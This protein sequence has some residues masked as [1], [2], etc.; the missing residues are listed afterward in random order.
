M[1]QEVTP[2]RGRLRGWPLVISLLLF[3]LF[4]LLLGSFVVPFQANVPEGYEAG[5]WWFRAIAAVVFVGIAWF[6]GIKVH[7]SNRVPWEVLFLVVPIAV[8]ISG[9][10]LCIASGLPRAD[11]LPSV[12]L[13]GVFVGI[14]E[15][16]LSRGLILNALLERMTVPAAVA[17][18]S[19]LFGVMH[20]LRGNPAD[21]LLPFMLG[22]CLGWIY[23]ISGRNLWLVIALHG[24]YNVSQAIPELSN[25]PVQY[26][27][28]GGMALVL[29]SGVL[30]T[31]YGTWRWWGKRLDDQEDSP[32]QP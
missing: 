17:V 7:R 5:D 31:I 11:L 10:I 28:V 12:L 18:S 21:A 27:V 32:A 24:I 23:V 13:S 29:V 9:D 6:T 15:E 25:T 3:N 22:V 19:L 8:A 2:E 26:G 14:Y 20:L 30:M 16:I 1:T 4:L